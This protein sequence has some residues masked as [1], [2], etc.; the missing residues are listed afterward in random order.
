M[1]LLEAIKIDRAFTDRVLNDPGF[2][3]GFEF[4]FHVVNASEVFDGEVF[5][6]LGD[7]MND[8]QVR[9]LSYLKSTVA[10]YLEIDPKQIV[11]ADKD[12]RDLKRWNLDIDTSVTNAKGFSNKR[13]LG[14]ELISPVM[15]IRDGLKSL[16]KIS[17]LVNETGSKTIR[18]KTAET[19]GLHINLSHTRMK[20]EPLDFVKL[21]FLFDDTYYLKEFGR[22]ANEYAQP[23]LQNM[24]AR[25][26]SEYHAAGDPNRSGLANMLKKSDVTELLKLKSNWDAEKVFKSLKDRIPMDHGTSVDLQRLNS[27]NP[28][29]EFRVAGN[30]GYENRMDMIAR[31]VIS[32]AA[33][34]DVSLDPEAYRKEYLTAVYKAL[35]QIVRKAPPERNLVVKKMSA[36]QTYLRP[37]M[38]A[39]VRNALVGFTNVLTSRHKLSEADKYRM[40]YMVRAVFN[41]EAG[42]NHFVRRGFTTLFELTGVDPK[43]L[44]KLLNNPQTLAK[45]SIVNANEES[46][47]FLLWAQRWLNA[48]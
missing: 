23:V 1:I 7:E 35:S 17:S 34:I 3:V 41:T 26:A 44:T 45:F 40:L 19:T 15:S 25:I 22:Q 21:A 48:F 12:N 37:I 39:S 20:K 36:I 13:D 6:P 33:L 5:D 38:N 9:A 4:E 31:M 10:E 29:V 42:K 14:V 11:I 30:V 32:F 43:E 28:Y 46:R 27:R 2:R 8:Q 47:P 18:F 16:Y 24:M